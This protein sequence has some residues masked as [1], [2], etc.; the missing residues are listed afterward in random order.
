MISLL[1]TYCIV[2]DFKQQA[3]NSARIESLQ[4]NGDPPSVARLDLAY[5]SR[6]SADR[7]YLFG[8]PGVESEGLPSGGFSLFR[9]GTVTTGHAS[10]Y[11][12]K[13]P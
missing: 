12:S 6:R 5:T 10:R 13:V 4:K 2:R 8:R 3:S 1:P 9:R 11:S 7:H